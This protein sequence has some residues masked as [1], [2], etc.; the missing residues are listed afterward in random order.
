VENI[1]FDADFNTDGK[2]IDFLSGNLLENTP[3]E[4]V[5]QRYMKVL[6]FDYSFKKDQMAREVAIFYGRKELSDKEGRPVRADIVVYKNKRACIDKN[7]GQIL[8]IVECKAPTERDGYNQLV[9]YIY[10]TSASGGVWF[11]GVGDETEVAYYRRV[12]EPENNLISWPQ[13]PRDGEAWDS[14]G[15]QNKSQL[16]RPNDIK[17]L[18]RRCHNKLHSRGTEDDDLTMDMV[19]II[20]AKAM[21]EENE[22][23][24]PQFYCTPEEYN[25]EEGIKNVAERVQKL[26]AQAKSLNAQVFDEHEKISVGNRAIADVV[27][28][29]Q[30]YQLLSDLKDSDGWDIMGH[31]YE[32]YTATYLKRK[33]GQ[34]FTN[35]LVI[36]LMVKMLE[37]NANDIILDPAG[38]SGGFLTGILRYVRHDILTGSGSEISKQR[39]LDRH[40]TRLFM[41]EMSKRLVKVAK[42][43]MILNGDGHAGMTQGDSLGS[44]TNFSENILAQCNKGTPTMI[45]TNPPFAGVGEGKIT[46]KEVLERFALGKVWEEKSDGNLHPTENLIAD[47]VPPEILFLERCI[48]WLAPGGK[49]GIVMPKG[50]LDTV[51]YQSARQYLLN[52]CKLLAVINCHKNTFQPYTGVRTTLIIAQKYNTGESKNSDYNIFMGFS[53]KI[54]QDSEGFPIYQLD[55]SGEPTEKLDH[56]LEEIYQDFNQLQTGKFHSSEYRFSIKKS[57]IREG[58]KINPQAYMPSLN[59]TVRKVASIDKENWSVITLGQICQGVKIFKGPRLKSENLIVEGFVNQKTEIYYPPTA[60]L[61]GKSESIKYLDLSKASKKQ[62]DAIE[63]LRVYQGDIVITRSGSIGRVTYITKQHNGVIA[64]DDLIRVR[65]PEENLRLFAYFYL[66]SNYAHDQMMRNEYGSIQQHLEPNHVSEILIPIPDRTTAI[67]KVVEYAKEYIITIEKSQ[68]YRDEGDK[69]IKDAIDKLVS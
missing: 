67:S 5:R 35:R 58:L 12:S 26:F 2:I 49:L 17:G 27:S 41:V 23:E 6:H 7:Q 20:L 50:F 68:A 57:E 28:E 59:E 52:S 4:K 61:Q 19:R 3:E 39:Q 10:N 33:N 65:I 60:I 62:L 18:L 48:D 55:E 43:A 32:Q 1:K 66:Q 63:K 24:L 40:R 16:R 47:G 30:E 56:D 34:F 21:D 31:A 25:S 37:P 36:D 38:G 44:Y 42:T 11:N 8:F 14:I 29:L 45:V 22:S 53:K 9:S 51:T 64:S 15:R 69:A 54:G 46:Q 13:L